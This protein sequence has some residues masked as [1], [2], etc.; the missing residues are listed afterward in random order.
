MSTILG[1]RL[2]PAASSLVLFCC[3]IGIATAVLY[4][5]LSIV[6]GLFVSDAS[7]YAMGAQRIALYGRFDVVLGGH[8]LPS[9][10]PPVFP[11]FFLAPIAMFAPHQPSL[12]LVPVLF[13]ALICMAI[14]WRLCGHCTS[15]PCA[16]TSAFISLLGLMQVTSIIHQTQ[17]VMSDMPSLMLGLAA[18]WFFVT[19]GDRPAPRQ[20][21]AAGVA[22]ALAIG[23][24]LTNLALVLPF[25]LLIGKA[26][27]KRSPREVA[28]VAAALALPIG[29]SVLALLLYNHA[30]FGSPFL[31]GYD[32][33]LNPGRD[34]LALSHFWP[35]LVTLANPFA[36][37][38]R[39]SDGLVP[40]VG[41]SIGLL[42][43]CMGIACRQWRPDIWL[44]T[45]PVL[46]FAWIGGGAICAFHL[47]YWYQSSR[48][49][50]LLHT[51]VI[52]LGAI[53]GAALLRPLS[54]RAFWAMTV[55]AMGLTLAFHPT[56]MGQQREQRTR[57]I[58]ALD[59]LLPESAVLVADLSPM[60]A[61]IVFIE[62][63]D[64]RF[65]PLD[66]QTR[67]VNWRSIGL[68][69][70]RAVIPFPTTA[71]QSPGLIEDLLA[72]GSRVFLYMTNP[73]RKRHGHSPFGERVE[74]Q[75]LWSGVS[76]PIVAELHLRE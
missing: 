6:S 53:W 49:A 56:G 39:S 34:N 13:S 54:D 48:F 64:R 38:P 69:D 55:A 68:I 72:V 30:S 58:E 10:Y 52:V 43:A 11:L 70:G 37:H 16:V 22:I 25:L 76:G 29:V 33:W 23:I 5:P 44:K 31:T 2:S 65:I 14:V 66:P 50:L 71:I 42:I 67:F 51:I 20:M 45:R 17:A 40:F 32:F 15:G 74:V 4:S 18:L 47:F 3:F 60:L 1:M 8:V 35:N 59:F 28:M 26:T 46:T 12:G 7:E 73:A 75:R 63:H 36:L 41:P 24:R 61:H 27:V 62:D 57:A 9:R 21:L 19:A